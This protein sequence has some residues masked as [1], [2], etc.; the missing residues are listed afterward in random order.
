MILVGP[1]YWRRYVTGMLIE[2]L[3]IVGLAAAGLFLAVASAAV[4]S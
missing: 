3:F 1:K 2:A 4:L